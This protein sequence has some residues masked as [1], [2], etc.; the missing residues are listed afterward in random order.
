M[1]F[2]SRLLSC[3]LKILIDCG[4]FVRCVVEWNMS[5]WIHVSKFVRV[6]KDDAGVIF[7]KTTVMFIATWTK[8]VLSQ[9]L[10]VFSVVG[11][12]FLFV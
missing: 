3:C 8:F 5:C 1:H 4:T 10:Q 11:R 6:P 7:I 2:C 12:S 9:D